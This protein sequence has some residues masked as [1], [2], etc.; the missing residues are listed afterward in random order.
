MSA[1]THT[2]TV[3]SEEEVLELVLDNLMDT[4][5]PFHLHG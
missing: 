3:V 4:P 5:H 1:D 2:L